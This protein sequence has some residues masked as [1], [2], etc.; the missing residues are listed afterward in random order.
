MHREQ[1]ANPAPLGLLGFGEMNDE[2]G[3]VGLGRLVVGLHGNGASEAD[4]GDQVARVPAVR[5]TCICGHER[6]W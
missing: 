3:G 1:V 5:R 4:A 2:D 6:C